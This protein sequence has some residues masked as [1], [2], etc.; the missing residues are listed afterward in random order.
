MALYHDY[1]SISETVEDS[2]AINNSIRN[3]ILTP[4]GSLPSNPEFGTN[5]GSRLFD[6]LDHIT[7]TAMRSTISDALNKF[8]K[9]IIVDEIIMKSVPEYNR[10]QI[11]INYHYKIKGIQT[12][13]TLKISVN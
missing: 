1:V 10:V 6:Q 2:S 8:E 11:Q 7:E 13:E 3:I 5:L 9:R 12:T 4:K